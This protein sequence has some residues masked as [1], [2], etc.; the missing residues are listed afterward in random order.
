MCFGCSNELS[1]GNGSFEY[2]QHMFC[3]R[4]N[5]FNIQF[6]TLEACNTFKLYVYDK[7]TSYIDDLEFANINQI[8]EHWQNSSF[9]HK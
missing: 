5:K 8:G 1:H 3:L 9:V 6:H 2:P 7:Q 4:N